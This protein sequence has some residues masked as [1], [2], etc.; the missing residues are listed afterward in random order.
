MREI[1]ILSLV[2]LLRLASLAA[3]QANATFLAFTHITVVDVAATNAKSA[4]TRDQTVIVTADHIASVGSAAA[5]KVPAGARVIDAAGKYLI[6]G[7]WDMHVHAVRKERVGTFFPLF[8]AN[9]VTG[10]RD[11]G[12]PLDE[13]NLFIKEWRG[14]ISTGTR[15][16]PRVFAAGTI[17]DGMPKVWPWSIGVS[18]ASDARGAVD[19]VLRHGANFVKVYSML[20]RDAYY[21]IADEAKPVCRLDSLAVSDGGH[22]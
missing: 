10:I 9:G 19:T 21:A 4:L 18:D 2:A 13:F 3:A 14:E 6:P 5:V 15:M 12:G 22:V 17:I 20:S 8:V 16:G 1:V 11:M 7:L